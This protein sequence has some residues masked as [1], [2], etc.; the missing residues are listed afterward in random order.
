MEILDIEI[1][2]WACIYR[3]LDFNTPKEEHH[4][5]KTKLKQN[6]LHHQAGDSSAEENNHKVIVHGTVDFSE[7]SDT[8]DERLIK[9]FDREELSTITKNVE[10]T[11][12]SI[13]PSETDRNKGS[14]NGLS[15][16]SEIKNS[17]NDQNKEKKPYVGLAVRMK[18]SHA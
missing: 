6:Y 4:K 17:S 8:C 7:I 9:D 18:K 13:S 10:N 14:S 5:L 11:N 3:I 2:I 1:N 15:K 16:L 12:K